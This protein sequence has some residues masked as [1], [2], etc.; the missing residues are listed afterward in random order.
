LNE[1][2]DPN[3]Q[4]AYLRAGVIGRLVNECVS[5]FFSNYDQIMNGEFEGALMKHISTVPANAMKKVVDVSVARVYADPSVIEIELAGYR[6][7]TTLLATFI[8]AVIGESKFGKK[9]MKLFP[10]QFKTE[11]DDTYS[12]IQSVVDYVAGMTDV[13]ALDLYRKITGISLPGIG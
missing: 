5:V 13:Y 1:V 10:E 3:E 2:T 9:L 8:D 12:K 6:I 7:I 4:V 11:N